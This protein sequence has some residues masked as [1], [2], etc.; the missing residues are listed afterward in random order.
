MFFYFTPQRD[1]IQ[2]NLWICKFPLLISKICIPTHTVQYYWCFVA[3]IKPFG[4]HSLRLISKF[5]PRIMGIVF[6]RMRLTRALSE[7]KIS[8]ARKQIKSGGSK[9]KRCQHQSTH[10]VQSRVCQSSASRARF[11]TPTNWMIALLSSQFD[12]L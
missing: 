7:C 5:T 10:S 3:Q 1:C 12:S 9:P 4:D 11:I 8:D 6:E 2:V